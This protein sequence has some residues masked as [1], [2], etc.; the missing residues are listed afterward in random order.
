MMYL[1]EM[2]AAV[3]KENR[4]SQ[5]KLAEKMEVTRQTISNWENGKIMPDF[6]MLQKLSAVLNHDFISC[7]HGNVNDAAMENIHSQLNDDNEAFAE[8]SVSVEDTSDS[9][10]S[11]DSRTSVPPR[12]FSCS[13]RKAV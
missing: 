12:K 5:E 1:G 3:R 6:A 13:F 10:I 4:I 7:L 9:G 8:D 11:Q 2:I